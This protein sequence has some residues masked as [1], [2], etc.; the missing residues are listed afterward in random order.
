MWGR[1][2][3]VN[4]VQDQIDLVQVRV[5]LARLEERIVALDR[6]TDEKFVRLGVVVEA[7]RQRVALAHDATQKAIDKAERSTE[8]AAEALAADVKSRFAHVNE[9][10]GALSDSQARNVSRQEFDQFRQT[11]AEAHAL[12]RDG[13]TNQLAELKERMDR[14]EGRRVGSTGTVGA[15]VA[16]ITL[17]VIIVNLIIY[18][19][20]NR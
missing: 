2:Q 1:G 17:V 4:L 7:E 16:G 10:R 9:L 19:L 11:Y 18:A 14:N 5:L 15:I 20:S 6:V 3:G 8:K 13:F 12:L